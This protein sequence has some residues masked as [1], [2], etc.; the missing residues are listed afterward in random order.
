MSWAQ[1]KPTYGFCEVWRKKNR[2]GAPRPKVTAREGCGKAV[3]RDEVAHVAW[4][5]PV[6]ER[7]AG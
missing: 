5:A 3:G 2:V 1:P 7:L 6:G 4:G